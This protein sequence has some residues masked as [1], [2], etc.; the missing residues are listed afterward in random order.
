LL[1]NCTASHH[2][3]VI[4]F[5]IAVKISNATLFQLVHGKYKGKFCDYTSEAS[6]I[7]Q[8]AEPRSCLLCRHCLQMFFLRINEGGSVLYHKCGRAIVQAVLC[9]VGLNPPLGPIDHCRSRCKGWLGPPLTH[10]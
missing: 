3:R 9:G 1:W 7:S 8:T 10:T 4:F 2:G 5:V 6:L